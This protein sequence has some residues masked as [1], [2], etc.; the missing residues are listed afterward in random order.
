MIGL[1]TSQEKAE[2]FFKN[3]CVAGGYILLC[4]EHVH[5]RQKHLEAKPRDRGIW[6]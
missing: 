5:S 4:G 3:V 6:G 2:I 1:L